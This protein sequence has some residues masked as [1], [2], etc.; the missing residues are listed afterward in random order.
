[1]IDE[2]DDNGYLATPLDEMH[3]LLPPELEV[4]REELTAALRLLQS[5]DPPGVG[6]SSLSECLLLQLPPHAEGIAPQV[7]DCARALAG[8]HLA[9][10]AG[11]Q[12]DKLRQLLGCTQET[13][14][15]AHQLLLRLNPKPGRGWAVRT[16]DYIHPEI[17]V[18]RRGRR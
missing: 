2:L 4:D 17:I 12:L 14:R 7:L 16:A 18:R 10:L 8:E 15:Q 13:L 6:A 3:A 1:L 5:F 11:G 9:L